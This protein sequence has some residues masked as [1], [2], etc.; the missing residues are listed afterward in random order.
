MTSRLILLSVL[1]TVTA[2]QIATSGAP[3]TRNQATTDFPTVG[4]PDA[5]TGQ[6]TIRPVTT[7]QL[8]PPTSTTNAILT[9]SRNEGPTTVSYTPTTVDTTQEKPNTTTA[10]LTPTTVDTTQEEPDSTAAHL[11]PTTVDTTQEEPDTTAAHL[12]PTTVDTTQE[13]PDTTAAH[14][15]PTTVDTTQEEPDTT[16]AHLT[17][18]TVDTTQE[19]P[20]TTAAHLTPTTVDTTQEEPDTTAAHLTPTTVDTTQEEPDTTAAHLTPTTVDTTQEEPDTTAAHLTPTT[21]DTTQEEPDTTAAHLTPTTVDTTQEEPDTTA[22]HLTPTTVDTTQEEPDTTAAHLTPT[23]VDTTQEEPDTTAA[24]LT[25]TTVDTTQEEPDTTAAHLTPTTVDTTQEEPDTTAAHLTPTTVD[26]TQEEPDTTAA[27]LTPTTVDTTQEEPD[28]TAAHLTPTTVDTT[29]EEPDTTAAHLTPTTVDTTQEEPDTTA[30]HLTPTTVDTTQEEPD[31]TAAHLTATTVDTT[32]EFATSVDATSSI[33]PEAATVTSNIKATSLSNFWMTTSVSLSTTEC[34]PT[35]ANGSCS[36]TNVTTGYC[37]TNNFTSLILSAVDNATHQLQC[38]STNNASFPQEELH[39]LQCELGMIIT[40]TLN[41]VVHLGASSIENIADRF[42]ALH[43]LT[44]DNAQNVEF[45]QSWLC[46]RLIPILPY[47]T[48]EFLS[49]MSKINFSCVTYQTIVQTLNQQVHVVN[50]SLKASIYSSFILSFLSR[51]LSDP[52][53]L[54][55][56]ASSADWLER[57]FGEFS[58]YAAL[59]DLQTLNGNF[60]SF[61]SLDLLTPTQVAKLTLS[62][63]ALNN[64]D[65]INAVFDRLEDGHAF[66]NV[67]EFLTT[68]AAAP[69]VTAI[70]TAVRD[71]MMNRTFV[72]IQRV[73]QEFVTEDWVVWF[74]VKLTPILPS[75]TAEMLV[76]VTADI[77]CTNY[78]VIVKGLGMVFSEMAALR[79]QEITQVLVEYLEHF[80]T[81]FNTPACGQNARRDAQWLNVNLGLFSAAASYS[82]L[83]DLNVTVLEALESLSPDQKAELLLDPSTGAL[84]NEAVVKEV[85]GSILESTDETQ[86]EQF[87][88]AFVE[89]TKEGNVSYI[90]NTAV[91]DTMLNMTLTALASDFPTF[92]TSDYQLWFQVNLVVL[93]ASFQPSL[94]VVIPTNLSCDSYDAVLRGL[95]IALA[96]LPSELQEELNSSIDILRESPPDGCSPPGPVR[97]CKETVANEESLCRGLQSGPTESG[98]DPCSSHIPEYACSS[99]MTLSSGDLATLLSCELAGSTLYA[100]EMWKLFFQKSSGVLGDALSEN[101][102]KTFAVTQSATHALDAI[103]E[104][105]VYNFDAAELSDAGFVGGWFAE[106]LRPLLPAISGD[107]LSCLSSKN[108]TCDTYQ[109]VVRALD[110]QALL[111]GAELRETVVNEFIVPFLS[112]G[113]LADAG[114]LSQTASSADWLERNFGEFSEYA[115]LEDLQTLNGNFSSFGSLDLLTPTQVAKLT[116]SSGALNNTDQINAVFDRLEDGHAFQNVD[117]FLTT[118]AAAPEV[119]AIPTAVRDVMMNRTFVIIQ[120]VFQEFVTEDWVV[121]FT[122]KLTPILP[123]FTAEM[124]VTV[125]ADINC[126]NYR[127]IVK[128]LGMV[129][130]E[131]AALRIQE[132]TQVLVEYLEHFA[133]QFNTPACGQNARRD[134]QWLNINLGLFSTAASYS[135]LK[136]LNVTVLEALESLSPD[137]KAELLLDPSTGALENEAVVKEVLGS[138]LESTDETQLEQ[139]FE[140]FVEV[141]KERNV[142]RLDSAVR[143]TVLNMTLTA[144]EIRFETFTPQ[145]FTLWFQTYLHLFLPGMNAESLSVI[146]RTISC[147]TYREM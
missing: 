134:A 84:E 92:Q 91:R 2:T 41:V 18:T 46:V 141:T 135:D 117:E 17:P 52:G 107:L 128:G 45:V 26:T 115:A 139:F 127:V 144:L 28:T 22:A 112:R 121:W 24:H 82:D 10:H 116:L 12:T 73:F 43:T 39:M 110:A 101:S 78:R 58:E 74:T 51:E 129:F 119:T 9:T 62:S 44:V 140:A 60:S 54:S 80:A 143:S 29:Q 105:M 32:Q 95:E 25:P 132:I 4:T 38:V 111:M 120:R 21:V 99:A 88:E 83:K 123:S 19:E 102:N 55:Q 13:E 145:N 126:T 69:E 40:S 98:G 37:N 50:E 36:L 68:L 1:C 65:Q 11:T 3:S 85:L 57:N 147:D 30:A 47:I 93:L 34:N 16:A 48:K 124:L 87:F 137:Q 125:T 20:D 89:V 130:S 70:P 63:G 133:T 49:N 118:L 33:R 7:E 77:N 79:I 72:I 14:L 15:T 86:L 113:D 61:G 103:G 53:C 106:K 146:P 64:T 56:T 100:V 104:V 66:Q 42:G 136:D 31:T 8:T 6:N 35:H 75:F 131:M 90:E 94:L 76:T 114:C 23:T 142:S 108:F 96:L 97:V 59:E 5:V 71:V 138:I 27:H 81:Q 109:V 122:V 67:D